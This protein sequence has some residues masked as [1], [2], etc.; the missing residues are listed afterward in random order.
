MNVTQIIV[1]YPDH[2]IYKNSFMNDRKEVGRLVDTTQDLIAGRKNGIERRELFRLFNGASTVD[3]ATLFV[4]LTELAT[5]ERFNDNAK[6]ADIK[7]F[8][9]EGGGI[10]F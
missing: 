10:L 9:I 6:V 5:A 3:K 1:R 2:S 7:E 8:L 4:E